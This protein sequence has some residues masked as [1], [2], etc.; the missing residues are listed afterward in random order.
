MLTTG[1]LVALVAIAA[2]A[3]GVWRIAA[4]AKQTRDEVAATATQL[5]SQPDYARLTVAATNLQLQKSSTGSYVGATMPEGAALVRVDDTSYCVQ[6]TTPGP[7]LHLAGPGG[8]PT[9][10]GC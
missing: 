8:T 4:P 7:Q 3:F 2:V 1:R 9:A 5:V 6:V 10:G